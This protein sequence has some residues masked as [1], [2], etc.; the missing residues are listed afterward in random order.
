MWFSIESD[1]AQAETQE[2]TLKTLLSKSSSSTQLNTEEVIPFGGWKCPKCGKI[3]Q[4]YEKVCSCGYER[5]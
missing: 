4:G 1:K 5:E 2:A 3:H